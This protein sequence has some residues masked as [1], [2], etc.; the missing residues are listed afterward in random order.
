VIFPH[1]VSRRVML[2]PATAADQSSFFETLLRTGIESFRPAARA[3]GA[4][5][6]QRN[7]AF[8]VVRRVD[9]QVLGFSTLH[10]LDPAGHIRSGIYLDPRHVR[11]GIGAEAV[12]LSINWAFAMFPIDSIIAQTTEASFGSFGMTSEDTEK[13][14]VLPEHLYFRGRLWDLHTFHIGRR[15][16][17][18]YIDEHPDGV[19]PP[20]LTWRTAPH[21]LAAGPVQATSGAQP[22]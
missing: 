8:L 3:A 11:L 9:E 16:W 22:V 21:E 14:A 7:A 20:P 6:R 5:A 15:E 1:T 10:G 13:A 12:R 17:E 18:E 2:R 19:L 4:V